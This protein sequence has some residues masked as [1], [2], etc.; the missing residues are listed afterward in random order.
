MLKAC[1]ISKSINRQAVKILKEKNISIDVWSGEKS[2]TK[3]E[4]KEL[5]RIYDILIIGVKEKIT[6]DMISN[7]TSPKIIGTLSIGLDHIDQECLKS[8]FINVVNCPIANTTSVAE[9][10]LALILDSTKRIQEANDLV[11]DG[12]G[13]KKF[14]GSKPNDISGKTIGLIGAGNIS[15][16]LVDI[17]NLFQMPIL[18]YTAHPDNHKDLTQ[19]GVKFV[20]LDELLQSSDIVNVSV[21]LTEQTRNLISREKIGLLREN[22]IFINTSRTEITDVQALV[23]F[24]DKNPNSYLGLDIDI[25]EYADLLSKRRNNVIVTPHIA[26]CTDEAIQ[27]TFVECAQNIVNAVDKRKEEKNV[28]ER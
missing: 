19:K 23:E 7:I 20:G 15:R 2:P 13:D 16:K 12:K 6:K 14:L 8:N 24:A 3:D 10:I 22:S 21:P 11:I 9:H 25:G 5:L 4:L 1:S 26:G 27:R 28:E 18:C 17:A